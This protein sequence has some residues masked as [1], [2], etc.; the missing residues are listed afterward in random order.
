VREGRERGGDREGVEGR[1]GEEERVRG[2][3]GR[4]GVEEEGGRD[5]EKKGM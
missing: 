4:R 2:R 5:I 1:G 3:A